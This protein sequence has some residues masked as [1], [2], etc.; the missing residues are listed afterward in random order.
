TDP[1][2]PGGGDGGRPRPRVPALPP[3]A[4]LC[5]WDGPGP[6]DRRLA[7]RARARR[8]AGRGGGRAGRAEERAPDGRRDG[9]A[10][11][12]YGALVRGRVGGWFEGAG[13]R[14]LDRVID[15]PGGARAGCALREEVPAEGP[16]Q[17]GRL[18][19]ALE[20]AGRAS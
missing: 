14:E 5:R 20:R 9:G 1:P 3:R 4:R 8:P 6:G 2:G 19:A 7:R 17:L 16:A 13:P 12:R 15:G 11:A 10:V 18:Q